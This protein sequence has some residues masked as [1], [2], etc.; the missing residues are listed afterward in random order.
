MEYV[1]K[2][3]DLYLEY[4]GE[5]RARLPQN[6]F[7][8]AS[9]VERHTLNSPHSLHDSWLT[10]LTVKENRN[11]ERPFE[12]QP[13]IELVLLGQMHDREI[14]LTY[15]GVTA[16]QIQGNK[17]PYNWTD[18]FQGDVSCHEVRINEQGMLVHE[19]EFVSNSRITI[20]CKDFDCT[21]NEYT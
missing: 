17:N 6:V 19:I 9:N 20:T 15:K 7:E 4:L 14:V 13:T 11:K 18:T 8:F 2:S 16:Y 10:S 1:D 12:P 5:N 3:F 21:E